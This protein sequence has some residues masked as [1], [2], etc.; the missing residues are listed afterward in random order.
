[1]K[2]SFERI[3]QLV[4]IQ[5]SVC[6]VYDVFFI[7]IRQASVGTWLPIR[8]IDVVRVTFE[9]EMSAGAQVSDV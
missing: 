7:K 6:E 8:A 9:C 1:M 2:L 5:G 3:R 4:R